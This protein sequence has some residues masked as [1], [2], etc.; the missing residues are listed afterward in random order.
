MHMFGLICQIALMYP[1]HVAGHC[2][3]TSAGDFAH[4]KALQERNEFFDFFFAAG[5][6]KGDGF[7]REVDYMRS[8]EIAYFN[9]LSACL[10]SS[11]D[12]DQRQFARDCLFC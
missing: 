6:F 2:D 12:L 4:T 5:H 8:E 7:L 10:Y 3:G 9:N 11:I 1:L